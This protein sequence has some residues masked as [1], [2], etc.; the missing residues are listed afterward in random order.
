MLT[1][2]LTSEEVPSE[3]QDKFL[4]DMQYQESY[5]YAK[6][7]KMRAMIFAM[8]D[9]CN[10]HNGVPVNDVRNWIRGVR[11]VRPG[12]HRACKYPGRTTT[13]D[14]YTKVYKPGHPNAQG[15][16]Y[17]MEHIFVMSEA[18]GRPIKPIESVH[19]ID[20]NKSNNDLSNL[21]LRFQY[22]GKGQAWECNACGSNDVQ[23]VAL[24]ETV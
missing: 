3:D 22:H 18:L 19:H 8:C 1:K 4:Y 5:T 9:V 11:K 20:G 17:V 23:P 6:R 16:G 7:T 2:P 10:E 24:K 14:G 12:T 21:Q 13:S 15:H